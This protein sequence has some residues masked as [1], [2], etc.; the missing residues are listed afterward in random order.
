MLTLDVECG[1]SE[2]STRETDMQ[3]RH[4]EIIAGS[5]SRSRMATELEGNAQKRNAGIQGIRLVAID[6]A[7]TMAHQNPR[8]D[9]A[10]FME[11]CG[12]AYFGDFR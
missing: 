10:R 5:I 8:F 3:R 6:L 11:A 7:A 4:F 2:S 9:R 12:L 1:I